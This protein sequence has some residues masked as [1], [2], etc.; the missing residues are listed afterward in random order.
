LENIKIKDYDND[1]IRFWWSTWT[2]WEIIKRSYFS[3]K[4]LKTLREEKTAGL[5][6]IRI[7]VYL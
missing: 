3:I 2:V 6:I 1:I 4:E 7:E 5:E